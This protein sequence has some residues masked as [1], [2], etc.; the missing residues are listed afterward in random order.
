[1]NDLARQK[2]I[3]LLDAESES[4]LDDTERFE[5]LLFDYCGECRQEIA[6]LMAAVEEDVPQALRRGQNEP[7][8]LL[9]ARLAMKLNAERSI[10]PEAAQW[11][12]ET[13]AVALGIGPGGGGRQ[14]AMTPPSVQYVSAQ[15]S[16]IQQY[17]AQQ[18]SAQKAGQ[19][20]AQVATPLVSPAQPV[21]SSVFCITCGAPNVS[22]DV[23]CTACGAKLFY[24]DAAPDAAS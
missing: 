13:W 22:G 15:V 1:M 8:M 9:T 14:G 6:A 18:Y 24:P 12:V 4:A 20:S 3:R 7:Y 11:A 17:S 10:Y 23:F 19:V 21:A 5:A 2:L 16:P